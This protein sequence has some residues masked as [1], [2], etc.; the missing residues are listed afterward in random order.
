MLPEMPS[1]SCVAGLVCMCICMCVC[2]CVDIH[3]L[4]SMIDCGLVLWDF[5]RCRLN[6]DF[7]ELS[8]L[9]CPSWSCAEQLVRW[10]AIDSIGGTLVEEKHIANRE[11]G[12][13]VVR[14]AFWGCAY[15]PRFSYGGNFLSLP[16]SV[17][18]FAQ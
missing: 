16:S 17:C 15:S 7:I 10:R 18:L 8:I 6:P 5:K 13:K 1:G 4:L 9:T 11:G 3:L 2:V 14:P 12:R